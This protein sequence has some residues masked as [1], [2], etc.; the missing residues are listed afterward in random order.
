[1]P[2]SEDVK[3]P[4]FD[5]KSKRT[6]MSLLKEHVEDAFHGFDDS[7]S[8]YR[9]K[10][11]FARPGERAQTFN[12]PIKCISNFFQLLKFGLKLSSSC[13]RFLSKILAT[14]FSRQRM[15]NM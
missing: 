7:I 11:H 8:K 3:T 13:T 2:Y 15:Q 12:I 1:M 5:L 10:C 4:D 14:I 6:F 9:G